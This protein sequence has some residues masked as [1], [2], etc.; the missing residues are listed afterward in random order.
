MANLRQTVS[1]NIKCLVKCRHC[2]LLHLI[3]DGVIFTLDN[4]LLALASGL[5]E[6]LTLVGC[7]RWKKRAV[8]LAQEAYQSPSLASIVHQY[9]WLEISLSE[10]IIAFE[11]YGKLDGSTLSLDAF[12]ALQFA[13]MAVEANQRLSSAGK[14]VLAGRLRDALKAEN[15]FSSLYLELDMA[16]RLVEAGFEI[17]FSDLEGIAQYDLRFWNQR[18]GGEIECKSLSA[19]AG[20]KIHR[21]DFYRFMDAVL[22]QILTRAESCADEVLLVTLDDRLLADSASQLHLRSATRRLLKD[23]TLTTIQE[24]FFAIERETFSKRFAGAAYQDTK[25]FYKT[26]RSAYGEN[27][28]VSGVLTPKSRCLVV[29]R[30]KREDDHSKPIQEALKKATTQLSRTRPGFIAVQFDD[31]DP[32]YLL[33][34]HLRRRTGLISY[35]LF[36]ACAADHVAATQFSIYGGLSASARGIAVPAIGCPNPKSKFNLSPTDYPSFL[37]SMPDAE[38]ARLLGA[39]PP[40]ENLS[41]IPIESTAP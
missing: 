20:R 27:C 37:V 10:Q 24:G 12:A 25:E 3:L 2:S 33:S 34:V 18:V 26:C 19:D 5:P 17:E 1:T 4:D 41:Y 39:S 6:F 13:Q 36:H 11:T 9:H 32:S 23:A 21:K 29:M 15:G 40:N 38:F 30:S 35:H 31:I 28:H 16:R 14:T 7:D 8:Q 22:P